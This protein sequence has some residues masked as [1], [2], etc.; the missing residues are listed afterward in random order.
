MVKIIFLKHKIYIVFKVN[1]LCQIDRSKNHFYLVEICL[2]IIIGW[3]TWN[4]VCKQMIIC[5][6]KFNK[7]WNG[8][9]KI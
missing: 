2:K 7:K 1:P 9:L 4:F 5:K 6:L 3:N 8:T